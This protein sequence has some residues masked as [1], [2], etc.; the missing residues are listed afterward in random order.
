MTY[1]TGLGFAAVGDNGGNN[2]TSYDGRAFLN[3]NDI[4]LDWSYRG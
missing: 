2:G 3:N 4:V 1:T